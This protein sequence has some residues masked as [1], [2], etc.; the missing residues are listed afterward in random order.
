MLLL[1]TGALL[2]L[3]AFPRLIDALQGEARAPALEPGTLLVA[4]P[5]GVGST[6]DKTVVLL[7]E[8]GR[9][10]TWGLVL[11]RVRTPDGEP[12][13][14]GVDRWGGPVRPDVRLTLAREDAA[15]A[16]ARRVLEGLSWYEGT[17]EGAG[18]LTFSGVS[19]WAPGQL[20]EEL[21][22]GAWWVVPGSARAVFTP[23]GNLWAEHA[24][25]HL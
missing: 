22:L 2:G 15:P 10:R 19:A 8:T 3:A 17:R 9:E 16:G 5:G 14:Q 21:A 12:L 1:L 25:Q 6:F 13:P 7:L 4:R 18:A 24:V 11:N 20:E 23:P